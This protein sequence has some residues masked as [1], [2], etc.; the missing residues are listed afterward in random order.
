MLVGISWNCQLL[1]E[2]Q[3]C[4]EGWAR[5]RHVRDAYIYIFFTET[6][7]AKQNQNQKLLF[8]LSDLV[9][10]IDDCFDSVFSKTSSGMTISW[11]MKERLVWYIHF[12]LSSLLIIYSMTDCVAHLDP[13]H[14]KDLKVWKVDYGE[15]GTF[16]WKVY[17]CW[18]FLM[19]KGFFCFQARAGVE[20]EFTDFIICPSSQYSTV[21]PCFPSQLSLTAGSESVDGGPSSFICST[22]L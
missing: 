2:S 21:L 20:R 16:R 19:E 4:N 22:C 8:Y 18:Q 7:C 17:S 12:C 3:S 11:T 10:S 15:D 14:T 13:Y 1:L 5:K 6:N 9:V